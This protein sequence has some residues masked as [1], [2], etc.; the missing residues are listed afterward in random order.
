ML[1]VSLI[2]KQSGKS[3]S[4]R[5][6][7]DSG[8]EGMII[9]HDFVMDHVLTLHTLRK[10]L[11]IKN[12]DSSLNKVSPIQHTTIQTIHIQT[13]DN[14]YHK[15][16]FKFYVTAVG[17]HNVILG[18]DWLKAH[19]PELDWTTSQLAFTCCPSSYILTQKPL[20]IQPTSSRTPAVYISHI[21]PI[22]VH[23]P[24]EEFQSQA[25][26]AW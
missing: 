3:I 17:T 15:E 19:N 5:A 16:W 10:P 24:E 7:L 25:T 22:S 14:Q 18:T 4:A 9:N 23:V 2:R 20:H 6:L 12:V 8:A 11:P 1:R 26:S 13:P 21:E